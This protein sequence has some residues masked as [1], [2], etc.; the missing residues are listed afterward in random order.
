MYQVLSAGGWVMPFIVLCS[1]IALAI[2]IERRFAPSRKRLHRHTCWPQ[3]PVAMTD[4]AK[5][6]VEQPSDWA[7][8]RR[9]LGYVAI[10][11]LAFFSAF[12]VLLGIQ[13]QM[14]CWLTSPDF[15]SILWASLPA[16]VLG[17]WLKWCTACGPA[18]TWTPWP[19]RELPYLLARSYWRWCAQPVTSSVTIS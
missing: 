18:V 8:Y 6:P 5:R 7:L 15:Y 4:N 10:Y 12:W 9:L 11:G 17:W 3:V 19:T 1:I 14:C 2:C 16:W 13:W